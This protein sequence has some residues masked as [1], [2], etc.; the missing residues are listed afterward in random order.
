VPY[1]DAA[2][3]ERTSGEGEQGEGAARRAE[4]ADVFEAAGHQLRGYE[5]GGDWLCVNPRRAAAPLL[6]LECKREERLRPS[7]WVKQ[8]ESEAA[9]GTVPV[10]VYRQSREPWRVILQLDDLLR[11]LA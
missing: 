11:L 7:E 1:L 4:V 5:A 6:H 9:A 8:A 10:V 3:S 2:L